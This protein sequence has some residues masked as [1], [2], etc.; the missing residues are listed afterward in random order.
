MPH[1]AKARPQGS[2]R[3]LPSMGQ[4]ISGPPLDM[5]VWTRA[6]LGL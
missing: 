5:A 3:A 2:P 6:S 4:S 1:S